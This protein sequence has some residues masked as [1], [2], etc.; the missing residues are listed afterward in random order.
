M[1]QINA[2]LEILGSMDLTTYKAF[3]AEQKNWQKNYKVRQK[4]LI[5]KDAK[6]F[7]TE[8]LAEAGKNEAGEQNPV[9]VRVLAPSTANVA[10]DE[11]GN[12]TVVGFVKS[13]R[14]KSFTISTYEI[15]AGEGKTGPKN[16]SRSYECLLDLVEAP[17]MAT[18]TDTVV[19][20]EINEADLF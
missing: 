12:K 6:A 9:Y 1:E 5:A 19:V 4:E 3:I 7:L 20:D 15:P 18:T 10:I 11:N 8:A 2:A 16:L 17:M 13:L 14:D